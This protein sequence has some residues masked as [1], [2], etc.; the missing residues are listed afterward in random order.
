QKENEKLK[1]EFKK[2]TLRC[3]ELSKEAERSGRQADALKLSGSG[4]NEKGKKDL[5][6]RL[7]QYVRDIDRCLALLNE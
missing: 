4:L 5:E 3:D 7:N 1:G 2:M 6:K